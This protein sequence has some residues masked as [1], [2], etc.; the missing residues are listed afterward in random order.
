M[1]TNELFRLKYR[2]ETRR[3]H[4]GTARALEAVIQEHGDAPVAVLEYGDSLIAVV[5]AGN[6]VHV[7]S[8]TG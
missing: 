6:G 5:Q 7:Y 4:G 1:D 8:L 3:L 2:P